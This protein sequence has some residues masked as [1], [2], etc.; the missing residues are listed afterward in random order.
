MEVETHKVGSPDIVVPTVDT[1]R[2]DSLVRIALADHK[3]MG[4]QQQ[5]ILR[6]SFLIFKMIFIF[7]LF[8]S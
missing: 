4:E 3:P 2:H 6:V 5:R 8:S 1:I 7:F